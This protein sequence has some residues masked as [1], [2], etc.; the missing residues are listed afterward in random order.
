[1]RKLLT[2][3]VIFAVAGSAAFAEITFSGGGRLIFVP[4]GVRFPNSD[5]EDGEGSE[6]QTYFGVDNPWGGD[7]P[8][9]GLSVKGLHAEGKMGYNIGLNL[10][11]LKLGNANMIDDSQANLFLKPFGGIFETFQFTF[12]IY[13]IDNLRYNLVGALSGFHNYICYVRGNAGNEDEVFARFK[14]GGFGTQFQWTPIENLYI[15]WSIGSVGTRAAAGQ[16]KDHGWTDAMISSQLGLGYTINGIGVAR[17]QYIGPRMARW[18][19]AKGWQADD[20]DKDLSFSSERNWGKIQAAFK[21]TAVQGLNLDIGAAIP[22]PRS[23]DE[24]FGVTYNDKADPGERYSGVG[25]ATYQEDMLVGFGVDLTK[26]NPVRVWM[27]GFVKFAGYYEK[28]T[29]QNRFEEANAIKVAKKAD[30]ETVKTN[31][32]TNFAMN[33]GVGYTVAPNNI[34]GLDL[35]CDVRVGSDLDANS[36][37]VN[38]GDADPTRIPEADAKNNYVDLGFGVWYR[39]NIAGGDIRVGVTMKLPGLAGEA[40]EGAAPQLYIPIMFNYNF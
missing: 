40:H 10:E 16:F 8:R 25:Y 39:R 29:H 32:G 12:G 6:A 28:Y 38:N 1:M 11:V 3:L 21:V 19:D 5:I 20:V 26:F 9:L 2:A 13:Q 18:D 23:Y 4:F 35:F 37:P 34:V 17:L 36:G 22:I 24:P 14:S 15:G 30:D 33:L 31:F 27:N 7:G